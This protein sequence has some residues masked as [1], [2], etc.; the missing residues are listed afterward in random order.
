M[1]RGRWRPPKP[2]LEAVRWMRGRSLEVSFQKTKVVVIKGPRSVSNSSILVEE[3]RVTAK[4]QIKNPGVLIDINLNFS[5][6]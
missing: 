5:I 2:V 4:H 1:V 3:M 6:T